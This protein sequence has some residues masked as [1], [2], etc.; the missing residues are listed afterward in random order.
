[1]TE[2]EFKRREPPFRCDLVI[3]LESAFKAAKQLSSKAD[4]VTCQ[5]AKG[6]WAAKLAWL[7][8]IA[9]GVGQRPTAH[10]GAD[11]VEQRERCLRDI[12]REWFDGQLRAKRG[13]NAGV[14]A[15]SRD[16]ASAHGL[17]SP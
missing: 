15:R 5:I 1:M 14:A 12:R 10:L 3:V 6:H 2:K 4:G 7:D 17:P 13:E 11:Q 9:N 16:S 8:R